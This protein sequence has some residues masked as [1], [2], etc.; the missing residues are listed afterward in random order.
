MFNIFLIIPLKYMIFEKICFCPPPAPVVKYV[1]PP[2][3]TPDVLFSCIICGDWPNGKGPTLV[4]EPGG[5]K[6]VRKKADST[7]YR[8]LRRNNFTSSVQ[9]RAQRVEAFKGT[10]R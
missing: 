2:G 8:C 1:G 10:L 6:N 4:Q 3:G 5:G 7:A 9:N